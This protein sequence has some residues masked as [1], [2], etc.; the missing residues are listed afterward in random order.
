MVEAC[1]WPGDQCV[2]AHGYR[3]YGSTWSRCCQGAEG[4]T[5]FKWLDGRGREVC[6]GYY[7]KVLGL[8]GLIVCFSDLVLGVDSPH[9]ATL[10]RRGTCVR[11][12]HNQSFVY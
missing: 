6:Q 8:T 1:F 3:D 7:T 10:D 4:E 5:G 2:G 9:R 12:R 11:N